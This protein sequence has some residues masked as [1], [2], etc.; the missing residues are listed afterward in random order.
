MVV[1][2]KLSVAFA[3]DLA[4]RLVLA[5]GG[6]AGVLVLNRNRL[7]GRELKAVS[8]L[9]THDQLKGVFFRRIYGRL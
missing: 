6:A 7:F 5:G 8:G 4:N 3:A 9:C 1:R 2:V